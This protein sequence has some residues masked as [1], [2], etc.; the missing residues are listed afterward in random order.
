MFVGWRRSTGEATG[1]FKNR[2][3]DPVL[4]SIC[5][6]IISPSN[7][8]APIQDAGTM[9]IEKFTFASSIN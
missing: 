7:A 9:P 3:T 5:A 1:N 2:K 8:V 4:R 6:G